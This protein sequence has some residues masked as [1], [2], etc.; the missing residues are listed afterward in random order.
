[1]LNAGAIPVPPPLPAARPRRLRAGCLGN[2]LL[3]WPC[4]PNKAKV[5][6][7]LGQ[8]SKAG[9]AGGAGEAGAR[10]RRGGA[11]PGAGRSRGAGLAEGDRLAGTE[12]R[13]V[14]GRGRP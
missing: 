14:A 4:V 9:E 7:Q 10:S 1:M 11:G 6:A 12:R 13:G 8:V 5:E 3:T 2:R